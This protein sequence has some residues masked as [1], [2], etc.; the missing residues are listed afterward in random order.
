MDILVENLKSALTITTFVFVMMLVVDYVN[1]ITQGKFSSL[2]RGYRLRQYIITSLLGAIP[3]C[4]GAFMVVSFY[5]RGLISFGA[6]VG[7]M[8]ATSGDES[9]VMFGLFPKEALFIHILL[10]L[11]G[12]GAAILV[13]SI[14]HLIGM[15][16]VD[17]CKLSVLHE[18]DKQFTLSL[19]RIL[20]FFKHLSLSRFL[21]IIF[22]VILIFG[23]ITGNIGPQDKLWMKSTFLSL[24]FLALLVVISVSE[25]YLEKHLWEHI[26]KEHIW[27]VFLWSFFALLILDFALSKFHLE[28]FLKTHTSYLILLAG[29]VG[30][31]PESGPHLIFVM[32]FYKGLIPFS[33]LL[34]SCIV[35][36]GHGLL[37]L[38][39]CNVKVSGWVKLINLLF[40]L[41]IGVILYLIGV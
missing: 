2:I 13:D 20:Y 17:A 23:V 31:I 35:Q 34:V 14:S 10:F 9:F 11:L 5:I 33:V 7:C 8:I 26:V 39:S 24:T 28:S 36:D 30:L 40:G 1:F 38:L 16:T 19:R 37:P 18:E 22:F 27:R 6:L 25:H 3:G 4:L 15:D 29:L 12:I 32:M 41:M 21:L